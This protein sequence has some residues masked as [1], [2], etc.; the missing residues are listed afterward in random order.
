[1]L[2]NF[3][4]TIIIKSFGTLGMRILFSLTTATLIDCLLKTGLVLNTALEELV[5]SALRIQYL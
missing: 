2:L 1:M 4:V 3:F 5:H